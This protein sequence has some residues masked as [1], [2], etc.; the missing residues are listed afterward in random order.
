MI[1]ALI[2]DVDG[3]LIDLTLEQ[4]KNQLERDWGITPEQTEP[5][6]AKEFVDCLKGQADLKEAITP[7]LK[8][9]GWND[10]INAYLDYWFESQKNINKQLIAEIQLLKKK[11]YKMYVATNQENIEQ[12]IWYIN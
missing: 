7:Y 4:V 11:G 8:K 12:N 3:V 2:F 10:S 6:F 9:W 1:K 5:F